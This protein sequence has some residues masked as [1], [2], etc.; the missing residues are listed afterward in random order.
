MKRLIALALFMAALCGSALSGCQE[1]GARDRAAPD[2]GGQGDR[3][4]R[5]SGQSTTELPDPSGRSLPELGE[6]LLIALAQAKNHHHKADVYLQEGKLDEAIDSVRQIL[7]IAFPEGAPEGEDV[8]LD[9]RARLAKLL[10]AQGK[11]QDAMAVVDQGI[12]EASRQSF[13][14]ANLYTVKGEVYE[15]MANMLDEQDTEAAKEQART[16]RRSAIEAFDRS[17]GINSELQ[18][19]LMGESTP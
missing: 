2:Q 1:P 12:K 10:N 19:A 5:Q 18:R 14:L 11:T 17:I 7:A 3:S 6:P 13:F 16:A 9:A 15:A 8:K 4:D